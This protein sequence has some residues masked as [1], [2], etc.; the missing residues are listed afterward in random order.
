MFNTIQHLFVK[1]KQANT[2]L[3]FFLKSYKI[4]LLIDIHSSE[5]K[6][7]TDIDIVTNKR[8]TLRGKDELFDKLKSLG[9]RYNLKIDE[10][11]NPNKD[12]ENEII[13]VSSLLC[14]IPAIR[15]VIN[16]KK[17]DVMNNDE[18]V[19]KIISLLEEFISYFNYS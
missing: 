13:S 7:D 19:S 12:M 10:N 16:N 17:I 18:S 6:D 8:E 15:I 5:F 11:N 2:I 4:K 3:Q 1:I 9:I 14:K